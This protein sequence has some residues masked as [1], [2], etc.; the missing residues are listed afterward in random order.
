[1]TRLRFLGAVAAL[2]LATACGGKGSS[3]GSQPGT[4]TPTDRE[5]LR[6]EEWGTR[7]FYTAAEAVAALRPLWLSKRGPDGEVQVYIDEVHVGT[8][9]ML[10]SVRISSVAVI[11]HLDGIQAAARFG[12]NHDQGAIL[13]TTRGNQR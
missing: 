5:S 11:K 12:M 9:E 6:P 13:V 2:A 8:I 10:R 7:N 1:M 4:T 3:G